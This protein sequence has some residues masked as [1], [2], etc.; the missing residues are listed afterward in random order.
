MQGVLLVIEILF[1]MFLLA[2]QAISIL[3]WFMSIIMFQM[4]F[5]TGNER[6]YLEIIEDYPIQDCVKPKRF[7]FIYK[8]L[9]KLS[10]K[11]IPKEM[12]Y[13]ETIKVYGF[14]L[15]SLL[16]FIMFFMNKQVIGVFGGIYIVFY[17]VLSLLTAG[18]LKR[19]SFIARYKEV[20]RYNVKYLFWPD[21][22]PYPKMIGKCRIEKMYGQG[23]KVFATVKV[24]ETGEVKNRVLILRKNVQENQ[25]DGILYEICQVCYRI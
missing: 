21:N 1:I 10:Y 17:A 18:I 8:K 14:I 6:I 4:S 24:L 20:N 11:D 25:G 22:E 5:E 12:Y 23:K 16:S 9:N 7:K 2:K 13:C 19:K 15:Y 3:L